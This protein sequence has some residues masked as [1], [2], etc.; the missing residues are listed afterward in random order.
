FGLREWG[1]F[2]FFFFGGWGLCG[3]VGFF[4]FL[5]VWV[6]VARLNF[7]GVLTLLQMGFFGAYF[8]FGLPALGGTFVLVLWGWA[9]VRGD[10]GGCGRAPWVAV[11]PLPNG[12]GNTR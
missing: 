12:G 5:G 11:A 4:L 7:G 10:G 6:L 2:F 1:V 8:F 9:L 3:L